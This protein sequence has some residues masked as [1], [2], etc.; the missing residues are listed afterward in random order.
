MMRQSRIRT[1]TP[2]LF[3]C[4]DKVKIP[5]LGSEDTTTS[6]DLMIARRGGREPTSVVFRTNQLKDEPVQKDYLKK[7][8]TD[9]RFEEEVVKDRCF[10]MLPYEDKYFYEALNPYDLVAPRPKMKIP[11]GRHDARNTDRRHM[12]CNL[13]VSTKPQLKPLKRK[14]MEKA[15]QMHKDALRK[16]ALE[17]QQFDQILRG[18]QEDLG[19]FFMTEVKSDKELKKKERKPVSGRK[20]VEKPLSSRKDSRKE[21]PVLTSKPDIEKIE[22]LPEAPSPTKSEKKKLVELPDIPILEEKDFDWDGFVLSEISKSSAS[23]LVY[24]RMKTAEDKEKMQAM[25]EGWYGKPDHSE[26]LREAMNA[27]EKEEK[28]DD[29]K[30]K[31]KWKKKEATL[32]AKVYNIE[33]AKPEANDPYSEENKAPFYRQPAGIRRVKKMQEKEDAAVFDLNGAI[34]ATADITIKSYTPPP[35]PTLRDH[36][37]PA[38]GDKLFDTDNMFEQ[39]WLTGAEQIH[40]MKGDNTEIYM[41]TQNRYRKQLQNQYPN[42]PEDWYPETDQEKYSVNKPSVKKVERGLQRWHKLPVETDDLDGRIVPPGYDPEYHRSPD[43]TTRRITRNNQALTQVI[44]EWRAKWHLSG[45]LADSTTDDLIKDMADIQTHVR[46]KS[47]ATIAKAAEMQRANANRDDFEYAPQENQFN[48]PLGDGEI[49]E[50]LYVA[51][52][53]LL[54]DAEQHVQIA[55]AITLYSLNRPSDKAKVILHIALESENLVDRWAAA[56]CLA[57]FGVCNSLVVGEVI[58]QLLI[59]ED[60]IKH[61][62]A[63]FLLGKLSLFSPLVHGMVA[64]QLNSSSWRHKVIACKILPTLSGTINKDITNK[65]ADLMWNDWHED[66]RKSAAQC[67]GKTSHGKEVHDDMCNRLL[68]GDEMTRLEAINKIGQLGIMTAKLLPVFLKSFKDEYVSIRSEV[69]ITCGNLEIKDELVLEQLLKLSTFETIWKVK[70]LAIQAFGKI[71]VVTE[72]ITE[73]LLWAVRYEENAAVRAEAC[74]TLMCLELKTPEV[75]EVLQERFLVESSDVVRDEIAKTLEMF[76]INATEDMD[77][78]A[79]IKN[80]VRK[81]CTRNNI[82]AQITIKEKDDTK[83]ENLARMIYESEKELKNFFHRHNPY[84]E[85]RLRVDDKKPLFPSPLIHSHSFS[86]SRLCSVTKFEHEQE[87][88]PMM[89]RI[90]SSMSQA[91]SR[92]TTPHPRILVNESGPE[93]SAREMLTPTADEELKQILSRED[94]STSPDTTSEMESTPGLKSRQSTVDEESDWESSR[95]RSSRMDK[96]SERADGSLSQSLGEGSEIGGEESDKEKGIEEKDGRPASVVKFA[97]NLEINDIPSNKE[98][99]SMSPTKSGHGEG[100]SRLSSRAPGSEIRA[101]SRDA[102]KERDVIDREARNDYAGLDERYHEM[103][104]DLDIVDNTYEILVT[105]R[106]PE[107]KVQIIT[108]ITDPPEE[109]TLAA[110]VGAADESIPVEEEEVVDDPLPKSESD[111]KQQAPEADPKPTEK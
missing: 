71:G 94:T 55:A 29:V 16:A 92:S 12:P 10:H 73:T 58:H 82:A 61:E 38:V 86:Y 30:P 44:D 111:P 87:K 33:S 8:S 53:C 67:L 68:T 105:G 9:I 25:Y 81:L 51:L 52:E 85:M 48:F 42:P 108:F 31:K 72:E 27:A 110:D 66:V 11:P 84:K 102:I 62:K 1:N 93:T 21:T 47:I 101:F 26:F 74:H 65:L 104:D 3:A 63:I 88:E 54:E 77:M 97:S 39:E 100:V 76:G 106:R 19:G 80:E 23:W 4:A 70:A 41:S 109:H 75:A 34:N 107:E 36:V 96:I 89:Q 43:P 60:T 64:E 2:S 14:I 6:L 32:L 98:K 24:E 17:E 46:L 83:R 28:G 78:V 56:Q 90:R 37:N 57:H 95:P 103:I 69:C 7:I 45:Q 40:E 49:P 59:T 13:T 50:R 20:E 18:S 91:S 15:M 79:Q 35:L 99:L 5:Q 22:E